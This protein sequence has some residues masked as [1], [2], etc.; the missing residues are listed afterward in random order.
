MYPYLG[1]AQVLG[2]TLTELGEH[3]VAGRL[4][5]HIG[6]PAPVTGCAEAY[7]LIGQSKSTGMIVLSPRN[8]A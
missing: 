8:E 1:G 7:G 3:V 5:L 6:H 2:I 4:K